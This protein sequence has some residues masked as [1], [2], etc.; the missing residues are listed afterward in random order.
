M[1][2][3]VNHRDPGGE[4]V[5]IP[6]V[7]IDTP[8]EQPLLDFSLLLLPWKRRREGLAGSGLAL[9]VSGD[10]A[11][12]T[13]LSSLAESCGFRSSALFSCCGNSM[14]LFPLQP[15]LEAAQENTD[16]YIFAR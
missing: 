11:G 8:S 16:F 13:S 5:E 9:V 4:W 2:I 10:Q 1:G 7:T 3:L 12:S 14:V 15:A 6:G